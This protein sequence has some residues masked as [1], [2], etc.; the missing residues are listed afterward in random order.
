L[1]GEP[2]EAVRI[3]GIVV[4]VRALTHRG[5]FGRPGPDEALEILRRRYAGGEITKEQFEETKR[6]FG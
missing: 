1:R 4:L 2:G 5:V 6:T 3:A